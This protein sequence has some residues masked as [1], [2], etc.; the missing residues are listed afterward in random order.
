VL[1]LAVKDQ[2]PVIPVLLPG[3]PV[4]VDLPMFLRSR[5]WV[6]LRGGL[7][8]CGIRHLVWGITGQHPRQSAPPAGHVST[9]GPLQRKGKPPIDGDN[10]A[11][12]GEEARDDTLGRQ[13]GSS[14]LKIPAT[15][16][17]ELT[18]YL[19]PMAKFLVRKYAREACDIRDLGRQLGTHIPETGDRKRF[20]AHFESWDAGPET[21]GSVIQSKSPVSYNPEQLD[22]GELAEVERLLTIQIGSM[23]K[24]FV[25][26]QAKSATSRDD[27]Y[28]RLAERI[29]RAKQRREF[30]DQLNRTE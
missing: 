27:L 15:I 20:I 11:A 14:E 28:M 26:A 2:R 9:S 21:D 29:P 13:T 4:P 5:T 22:P 25:K 10:F 18:N 16:E 17:C 3:A 23:A 24:V 19:S 7:N 8:N 12:G 1:R 6:D 30:L